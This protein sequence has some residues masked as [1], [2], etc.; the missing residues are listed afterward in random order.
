LFGY[1]SLA[2]RNP[3]KRLSD[4]RDAEKKVNITTEPLEPGRMEKRNSF[5]K[6][7]TSNG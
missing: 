3:K 4:A 1:S 7:A 6:H 2:R 5:A